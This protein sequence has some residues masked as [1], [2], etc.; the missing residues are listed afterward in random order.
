MS[1]DVMG[2]VMLEMAVSFAK[3]TGASV[4]AELG[5]MGKRETGSGS[6]K[7]GK[8]PEKIY[9]DPKQANPPY[10]GFDRFSVILFADTGTSLHYYKNTC[11]LPHMG[12][13]GDETKLQRGNEDIC[14]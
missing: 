5:C 14:I 9:T 8:D 10:S 7:E 12:D 2:P 4:E 6:E 3:K 1:L 13:S 11:Q